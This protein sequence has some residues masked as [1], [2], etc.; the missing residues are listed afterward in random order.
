MSRARKPQFPKSVVRLFRALG[1]PARLRIL[2]A[3]GEGEACVC[4]LEAALGERQAYISQ[5]LMALRN[6]GL[7]V[8]RREGRNIYYR[9]RDPDLLELIRHAAKLAE[10]P[11]S[12]VKIAP[13][14]AVVAACSCPHCEE[15]EALATMSVQ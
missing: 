2:L 9:L 12:E 7:V 5:N 13:A 4:H 14:A 6:E 8:P 15:V 11:E 3:I 10:I 1:Q